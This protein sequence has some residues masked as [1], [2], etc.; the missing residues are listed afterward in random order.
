MTDL[1]YQG[2]TLRS[3]TREEKMRNSKKSSLVAGVLTTLIA[4]LVITGSCYLMNKNMEKSDLNYI[5]SQCSW[6]P[7]V[8]TQLD[9]EQQYRGVARRVIQNSESIGEK[10]GIDRL[11][12]YIKDK[13]NDHKLRE[14]DI[15]LK[16][17]D[18]N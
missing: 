6:K 1:I 2:N 3:R 11:Y 13:N 4:P 14:G 9:E 10:V 5:E 8:A 18:C 15:Y 7:T 16:P 12:G 17:C